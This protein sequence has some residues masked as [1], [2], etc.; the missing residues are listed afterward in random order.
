MRTL[1]LFTTSVAAAALAAS[2]FA[3][4]A[5]GQIVIG[6]Q[7]GTPDDGM[8][9][10]SSPNAYTISLSGNKVFCKRTKTVNVTLK[11]DPNS[12]FRNKVIRTSATDRDV[13]ARD[14]FNPP[15]SGPITG[16]EHQDYEFIDFLPGQVSDTLASEDKAEAAALGLDASKVDTREV[17]HQVSING[18]SGSADR[19]QIVIDHYIFAEPVGGPIVSGGLPR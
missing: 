14:H 5:S 17:S 11:C 2:V 16:V 10:R 1:D 19:G 18:G 15:S 9:C 3:G 6:N 12:R 13:C 4:P 8:Q 7:L